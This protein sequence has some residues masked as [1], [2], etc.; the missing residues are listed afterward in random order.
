MHD[1]YTT[2]GL[3]DRGGRRTGTD[4]RTFCIPGYG[5]ERRSGQDRRIGMERRSGKEP[6][7]NIFEPKRKT[8]EYV[9]F[10]GSVGGLFR[11]ICLGALLWEM[12]IISIVIIRV[13]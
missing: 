7:V 11:G 10:L 6:F 2:S 1:V 5:F 3:M 13:G 12:I 9:E 4:R 8:D